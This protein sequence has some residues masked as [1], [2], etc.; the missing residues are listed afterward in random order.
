MSFQYEFKT[1]LLFAFDMF[2]FLGSIIA[3]QGELDATF[4]TVDDGLQGD[5]FDNIVRTVALQADGD[6][7]VEGDYLYF[8]GISLPYLSRLKPDG[9]VDASFNLE[10]GFNGK[11]YSTL[12]QPD[13]KIMIAGSFTSFM[14]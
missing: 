7:I 12:I 2:S 4:N 13:G 6:L 10:S 9:T 11:V 1:T 5:G 8:D 3:Q 14:E